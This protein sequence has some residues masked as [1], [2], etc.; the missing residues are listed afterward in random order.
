[1]NRKFA[2]LSKLMGVNMRWR[3][4]SVVGLVSAVYSIAPYL[5]SLGFYRQI[6]RRKSYESGALEVDYE[7]S[8][9]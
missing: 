3:D 6:L 1:L 5:V 8:D 2:L 9:A 4:L 7:N